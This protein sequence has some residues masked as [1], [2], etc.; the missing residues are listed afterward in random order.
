MNINNHVLLL[1][2]SCIR[3]SAVHG[4]NLC[5]PIEIYTAVL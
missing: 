3:K 4:P 2:H 5:G 1:N